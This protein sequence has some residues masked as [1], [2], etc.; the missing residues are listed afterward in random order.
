MFINFYAAHVLRVFI[1]IIIIVQYIIIV[2]FV[3]KSLIVI[4]ITFVTN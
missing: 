3:D 1:F 4:W 2:F